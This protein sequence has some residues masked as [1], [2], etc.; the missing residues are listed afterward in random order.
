[1]DAVSGWSDDLQQPELNGEF[2][3]FGYAQAT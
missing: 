2:M 3:N 1:M